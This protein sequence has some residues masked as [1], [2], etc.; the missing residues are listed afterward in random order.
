MPRM[1]GGHCQSEQAEVFSLCSG[2]RGISY[3]CK[4]ERF[5]H[6]SKPILLSLDTQSIVR[7]LTGA[8]PFAG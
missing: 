3:S 1:G 6:G 7:S 5:Q 2:G 8:I 4:D